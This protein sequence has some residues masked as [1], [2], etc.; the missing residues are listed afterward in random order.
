MSGICLKGSFLSAMVT[1]YQTVVG[2]LAC[3]SKPRKYRALETVR[4]HAFKVLSILFEQLCSHFV[5][6]EVET[7]RLLQLPV[8]SGGR[9]GGLKSPAKLRPTSFAVLYHSKAQQGFVRPH[10]GAT[11]GS[12]IHVVLL[13]LRFGERML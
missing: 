10:M 2:L 5:A 4:G 6:S 8:L 9:L 7:L 3:L 12:G 11:S 1:Q 13:V